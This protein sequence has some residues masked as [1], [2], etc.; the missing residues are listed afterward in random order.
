MSDEASALVGRFMLMLR[1]AGCRGTP[2]R[3]QAGSAG[4]LAERDLTEIA[5][6]A[7][8]LPGNWSVET[9]DGENGGIGRALLYPQD[10]RALPTFAFLRR[11]GFITVRMMRPEDRRT[12]G[13]LVFGVF[14]S[15]V[16]AIDAIHNDVVARQ[17]RI[18]RMVVA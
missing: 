6:G 7:E 8:A 1:Q 11:D 3:G 16:A 15:V 18:S 17:A 14:A 9:M 4:T 13:S 5:D 2:A 12:A 10:D